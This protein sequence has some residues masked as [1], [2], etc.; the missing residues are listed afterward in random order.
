MYWP[1][2][3]GDGIGSVPIKSSKIKEQL[4]T[5]GGSQKFEQRVMQQ[6]LS[7]FKRFPKLVLEEEQTEHLMISP[8]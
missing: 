7:Q 2:K 3:S 6:T 1:K 8:S 5:V 4:K